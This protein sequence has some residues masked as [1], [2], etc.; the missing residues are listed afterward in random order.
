MIAAGLINTVEIDLKDEAG[1]I[2]YDTAVPL[3]HTIGAVTEL[4]DLAEVVDELHALG[5][6]VIGR[7]VVFRDPKLADHAV[8]T[9]AM[10]LV[11]QTPEGGAFGQY[12][13]FTEPFQSEKSG[14]T[15]SP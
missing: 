11:V 15:T 14:S 3:A 5:V 4:W 8:A 9:G 2:W 7:L 10:D 13:G 12:G 6:R 1:E